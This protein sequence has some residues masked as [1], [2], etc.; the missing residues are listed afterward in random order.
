MIWEYGYDNGDQLV[1]A[2]KRATDPQGT[3]LQRFASGYDQGGNRLFEQIDDT[4]TAWTYDRLNRL[5]T[6]Q[7]A[8]LLRVAGSVNEPA[9]VRVQGRPASIDA[10]GLFVGGVQVAPGTTRFT[11]TAT[12]A[13][14]NV[15]TQS[16]DVDQSG[17]VKT[18]SFDAN[19]NPTARCT[20]RSSVLGSS[21]ALCTVRERRRP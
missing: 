14:G 20:W 3:V 15:A 2:V 11:V 16:Y 7:A 13:S 18:F 9:T 5:V 1:R 17:G 12:D 21:R 4:V 19:G 10:S 6:Q 8:G